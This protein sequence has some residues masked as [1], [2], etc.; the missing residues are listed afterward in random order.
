MQR[1]QKEYSLIDKLTINRVKEINIFNNI[2]KV[3]LLTLF[4]DLIF[5]LSIF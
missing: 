3:T 2:I 5:F 1:T 4:L